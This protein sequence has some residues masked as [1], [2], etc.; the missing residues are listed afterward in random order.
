MQTSIRKNRHINP[1]YL[2]TPEKPLEPKHKGS[3][4]HFQLILIVLII[5]IH[6]CRRAN[7]RLADHKWL[8]HVVERLS[9]ERTAAVLRAQPFVNALLV[10]EMIAGQTSEY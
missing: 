6:H 10:H 5:D 4:S 9:T 1:R 8:A 3:P 2:N 7:C